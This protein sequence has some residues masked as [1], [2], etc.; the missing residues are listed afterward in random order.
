HTRVD[1]RP[2]PVDRS[3]DPLAVFL[4]ARWA[5]HV[6]RGG[7]RPTAAPALAGGGA[8]VVRSGRTHYIRNEHAPWTLTE[9]E[10]LFLDDEL[11]AAA[12]FPDLAARAP[13]SV[14]FAPGTHTRFGPSHLA[15]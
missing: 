2:L 11:L 4:T 5:L 9:A 3:D 14:L 13:D 6:A 15:G 12:G 10:L 1:V 8:S 7:I